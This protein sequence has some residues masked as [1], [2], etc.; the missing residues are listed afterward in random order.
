[1]I[2][3]KK[4]TFLFFFLCFLISIDSFAQND[5]TDFVIIDRSDQTVIVRE[6]GEEVIELIGNVQLRQDSINMF[7]DSASIRNQTQVVAVGHVII[8]QGDSLNIFSDSLI[9]DGDK[10][11]ADLYGAVVLDKIPY[12]LFTDTLNY[13]LN[14]KIAYYPETAILTNDTIQLVSK[15]GHYFVDTDEAFF[16]DSVSIVSDSFSLVTDTLMFNTKSKLATFL[17]PTRINFKESKI[18]CES[19]FYDTKSNDAEF[20]GNPQFLKGSQKAY[21]D[22][23]RYFGVSNQIVLKGNAH[24]FEDKARASADIITYK[25]NE[26]ITILDGNALYQ[27]K[28]RD[29][30]SGRIIYDAKLKRYVTEGRSVVKDAAQILEADNI[31]FAGGEDMGKATGDVFWQDTVER[32]TILCQEAIYNKQKGYLKAF[33]GNQN[34]FAGDSI[35]HDRPM[36]INEMNGDSIFIVSD[37]IISY[38]LD[39]I[40]HEDTAR[41]LLAYNDVRVYKTDMQAICDS[42]TYSTLDSMFRFFTNP[43]IWS[44]T[45]QFTGDSIR[46]QLRNDKI[47]KIFIRNNAFILN[48]PDEIFFNQIKGKNITAFFKNEE[49][50]KMKVIGNA[51][52]VYYVLDDEKAYIGVN[53]TACSEM[54]IYFGNNKVNKIKF[55]DH[56]KGQA[57]P[58]RKTDHHAL[59][60][61]GFHWEVN[62]RPKSVS[63]LFTKIDS[64]IAPE[65][66]DN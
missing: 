31:V 51:E 53:K 43:I 64:V 65:M 9:Y 27:D 18:Y 32:M 7:C 66:Q 16:K 26:D 50:Y 59:K 63:D 13:D 45:T 52:T 62:R 35:Q 60:L 28:E 29:I 37:T 1:M 25:Q 54:M 34:T 21:A 4:N 58:M 12:K 56:P 17:A 22:T 6:H 46:M 49:V 14:T 15:T 20:S 39:T 42:L 23:I 44:D 5:T 47:D 40:I 3:I 48:S 11:I 30:K 2:M 38:Q 19:G 61:G 33:G 24:Y 41:V 10:K 8:R 36:M 55:Y 57:L